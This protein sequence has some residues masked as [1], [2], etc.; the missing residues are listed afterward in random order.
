MLNKKKTKP[1]YFAAY[2]SNQLYFVNANFMASYCFVFYFQVIFLKNI[3][4]F[5]I[6]WQKVDGNTTSTTT[7]VNSN[8]SVSASLSGTPEEIEKQ[9]KKLK[10]QMEKKK[11]EMEEEQKKLLK[12][13]QAKAKSKK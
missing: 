7:K 1:K 13:G 11:K 5:F 4:Y 8:Y 10:K 6:F 3:L 9:K 2:L 12:Q